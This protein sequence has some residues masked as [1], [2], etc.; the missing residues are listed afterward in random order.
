M[1]ENN[2]NADINSKIFV[3]LIT[4]DKFY[5]GIKKELE[6]ITILNAN[7]KMLKIIENEKNKS[8]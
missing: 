5:K 2:F 1:D 6:K 4:N 7:L 8:I 3:K